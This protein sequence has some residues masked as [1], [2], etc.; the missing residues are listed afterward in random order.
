MVYF[1]QSA[2]MEIKYI[3]HASFL[4]KGKTATVVTDPFDPQMVGLKFPSLSADIVTISHQHEDH[5]QSKLISGDALII[6]NPGEYEKKGVRVTGV[7][8]FHDKKQGGERGKN[9]LYK[10]EV[11][12][13]AILHC[14]DLGHQLSD[15]IVE[16]LGAIDIVMIPTGGVY[17]ID[18]KEAC[19]VVQHIEPSIVIP[20][21]YADARLNQE[22][23]G[24]LSGVSDFIHAMG[25]ADTQAVK[26]LTVKKDE[27]TEETKVVVLE[28]G[29]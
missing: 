13:I 29:S 10:I 25:V 24:K 28:M 20:M 1:L 18:A 17:T 16:E 2:Y 22:V 3:G 6:T 7:S 21:H 27:L 15:E 9:T 8:V 14:G 11:D 4:I 26:K 12:D 5:N 23:F 19:E